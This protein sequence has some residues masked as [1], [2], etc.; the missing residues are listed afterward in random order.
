MFFVPSRKLKNIIGDAPK[1]NL[2]HFYLYNLRHNDIT[3]NLYI[4]KKRATRATHIHCTEGG[5]IMWEQFYP[6]GGMSRPAREK[7]FVLKP[8][9]D[10]NSITVIIIRGT[11]G[12][13]T[14]LDSGIF[15]SHLAAPEKNN[16]YLMTEKNLTK[17]L[18]SI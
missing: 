1:Q 12:N 5:D 2:E 18:E 3:V 11:P 10:K 15:K 14:G 6:F 9:H 13:I 8:V 7:R 16:V 4:S 17:F